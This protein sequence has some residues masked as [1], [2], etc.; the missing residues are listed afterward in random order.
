MIT[1]YNLMPYY[2]FCP[3]VQYA[4]VTAS[5]APS[6]GLELNHS[7]WI[8]REN[9]GQGGGGLRVPQGQG[10]TDGDFCLFKPNPAEVF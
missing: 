10:H 3:S 1:I 8:S 9:C 6:A 5:V 4:A 7:Q 2:L